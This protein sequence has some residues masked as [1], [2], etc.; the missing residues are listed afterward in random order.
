MMNI[1][2]LHDRSKIAARMHCDKHVVKMCL[3]TA[4]ILSTV[5][6]TA[7]RW[8]GTP[9]EYADHNKPMNFYRPTHA[10]HPCVLWA[11]ETKANFK[12]LQRLGVALCC[13]Y[14]YRY[15]K[16]HK[17]LLVIQDSARVRSW[18]FSK[19]RRRTPFPTMHARTIP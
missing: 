17:S 6:H 11:G 12:W 13:E 4:Q 19:N 1:F 18:R 2:A 9:Y 14:F 3:E 15:G 10:K 8:P 16:T 7:G 5:V